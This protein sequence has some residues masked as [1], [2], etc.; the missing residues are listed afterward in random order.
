MPI[1]GHSQRIP[2]K[3][4]DNVKEFEQN[5]RGNPFKDNTPGNKWYYGFLR[6]H[7]EISCRSPEVVTDASECGSEEDIRG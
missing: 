2:S 7:P 3:I 1:I 4:I 5:N 6:R